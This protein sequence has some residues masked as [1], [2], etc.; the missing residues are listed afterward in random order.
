MF[1]KSLEITNFRSLKK[2]RIDGMQPICIFHGLNNSGKSNIFAALDLILKSKF[3][4][5]APVVELGTEKK[6]FTRKDTSFYTGRLDGFEDNFYMNRRDPIEFKL[7]VEFQPEEL[8]RHKDI[9]EMIKPE[10]PGSGN[11]R[12]LRLS[13]GHANVLI[14]S[15]AFVYVDD[16]SCDVVTKQVS[17]NENYILYRKTGEKL[18]YLPSLHDSPKADLDARVQVFENLMRQLTDSFQVIGADRFL[19]TEKLSLDLETQKLTS[20]SFKRFLFWLSTHKTR[21]QQFKE[22]CDH[23]GKKPFPFGEVSFFVDRKTNEIEVMIERSKLRLP[24]GRLGSGVQQILFLIAS[25]LSNQKKII[26]IEEIELNLSKEAQ[27]EVFEMLK[28]MVK[29]GK[30]LQQV[31]VT[32][33]SP[34]FQDRADVKYYEVMYD[35]SALETNVKPAT[36][37][38]LKI[39]HRL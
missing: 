28:A 9:L 22:I 24:L 39:Y 18:D 23:F 26:A 13:D 8:K 32:S 17:L 21:H 38:R 3:I 20:E 27:R 6:E 14:V 10:G 19:G 1:I 7:R 15:G 35:H 30:I 33:H 5:D 11:R 4:V 16:Q 37:G 25:V 12:T 2:V 34:Y 29:S 36:K 31:I